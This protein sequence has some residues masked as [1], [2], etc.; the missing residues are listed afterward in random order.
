MKW[1]LIALA[2]VVVL[3]SAIAAVIATIGAR[4]PR[5]HVVSRTLR[6]RRTPEEVWSILIQTTAASSVP[7]DLVEQEAPRRM[8]TRVKE[9]EKM[10]GGT[11]TCV[12]APEP[13]GSTL[14]I[15]EDGWVGNP[16]FRFMS[17][18][19]IGHHASIDGVLKQ[20]GAKLNEEP[21]LSG[22]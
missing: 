1:I 15:T 13:E 20:V 7:V 5:Q 22:E 18:Y 17:R 14:T 19:V 8:V 21:V 11:W 16:V 10:F 4:L 6:V 9:T 3:V 12:I 2:L